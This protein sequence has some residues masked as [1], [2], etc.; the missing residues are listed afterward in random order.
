MASEAKASLEL[1]RNSS[2]V[3]EETE[4][5]IAYRGTQQLVEEAVNSLTPQQ[6]KVYRLCHVDGLKYEEAARQLQIAPGTVHSHMK[7]ALRVI[8]AHLDHA[9]AVVLVCSLMEQFRR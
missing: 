2:E 1:S 7:V 5:G 3:S 4:Q 9:G 6:Q 8:R